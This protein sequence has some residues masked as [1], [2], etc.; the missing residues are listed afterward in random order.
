MFPGLPRL[1]TVPRH[2][3]QEAWLPLEAHFSFICEVAGLAVTSEHWWDMVGEVGAWLGWP[4][5]TSRKTASLTWP[6]FPW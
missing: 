6:L 2:G 4:W 1:W 5:V 3:D